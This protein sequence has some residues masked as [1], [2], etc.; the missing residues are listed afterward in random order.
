LRSTKQNSGKQNQYALKK[1]SLLNYFTSDYF[2]L[3]TNQTEAFK[4][5]K[6]FRFWTIMFPVY[7]SK[8]SIQF[9]PQDLPERPAERAVLLADPRYFDVLYEI[10]PHMLGMIG[11]VDKPKAQ[12]QWRA[13]KNCYE[14]LGYTV[15]VLKAVK[16]LPDMVFCAN[17]SFPYIDKETPRVIISQM[18]SSFR[19][20]EVDH[21][22]QWYEEQ[23]YDVIRQVNP[24]VE[25]EGMG[26]ALWHPGRKLLYIGYG[27]RTS[28]GAL[29]R[30][31]DCINCPVVGLELIEPHFYH[32]DTALTPIDEQTALYVADAF[33]QEG[34]EVLQALF[35]RL[36]RVPRAEAQNGFVTNGHSPDGQHFIVNQ[37]NTTTCAAL[38]E[39]GLTI[40]EL[41]TSEF[42]KS[43]GSVF[44]MKMML[45]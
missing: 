20:P 27:Y 9:S 40:I 29:Q 37:G 4:E 26:D 17:Q 2:F 31:A 15:H 44:C 23:G 10:N 8:K 45:P 24:P 22:A 14:L 34:I 16:D 39:L 42:M 7:L 5:N 32:L 35:P 18:A 38:R 28:Q 25:F 41:D 13:L 12:Q 6:R 33:T 11:K 43:G 36:I 3:C 21:F 19:Q 1:C 30:A